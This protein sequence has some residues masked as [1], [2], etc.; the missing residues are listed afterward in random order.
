MVL[1]MSGWGGDQ[2]G[3]RHQGHDSEKRPI[4]VAESALMQQL[5]KNKWRKVGVEMYHFSDVSHVQGERKWGSLTSSVL[6]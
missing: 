6:I 5:H 3:G 2:E 4:A 1:G